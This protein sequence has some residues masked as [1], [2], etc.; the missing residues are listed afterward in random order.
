MPHSHRPSTLAVGSRCTNKARRMTSLNAN[1]AHCINFTYFL[2]FVRHRCMQPASNGPETSAMAEDCERAF[3]RHIAGEI[4][5]LIRC[6]VFSGFL[7]KN[8][9]GNA[10]KRKA[11][12]PHPL[13]LHCH[14]QTTGLFLNVAG[15]TN[16]INPGKGRKLLPTIVWIHGGGCKRKQ[17]AWH[18]SPATLAPIPRPMD[19]HPRAS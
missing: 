7:I 19:R 18:V 3:P 17:L 2:H 6:H 13:C 15:P 4:S 10:W 5:A 14:R 16:M 12:T 8:L 1:C 9:G 11:Q